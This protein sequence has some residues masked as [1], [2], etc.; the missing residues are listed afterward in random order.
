MY[1]ENGEEDG[2]YGIYT[3]FLTSSLIVRHPEFF[4]A[5][6]RGL[7]LQP[8][9]RADNQITNGMWNLLFK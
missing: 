5:S 8:L 7:V 6:I 3:Q 2:N 9:G 4:D 1:D